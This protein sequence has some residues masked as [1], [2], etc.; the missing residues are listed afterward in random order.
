MSAS[1]ANGTSSVFRRFARNRA[2]NVGMIFGLAAIPIIGAMAVAV[3]YS[4]GTAVKGRLQAAADAA[5]LAAA[6]DQFATTPADRQ[7]IAN[8]VFRANLD[9]TLRI[10]NASITVVET[11]NGLRGNVSAN[12]PTEF[13]RILGSHSMPIAATAEVA[14]QA[15]LTEIALVLDNTGSMRNDMQVLR[16]AARDFVNLV[17]VGTGDQVKVAVV[18][19]VGAVNPGRAALGMSYMDTGAESRFHA[20]FF[21]AK[22]LGRLDNNC[23]FPWENNN[24]GGNNG[25][26]GPNPDPDN[27]PRGND[28]HLRDPLGA[29]D[30]MKSFAGVVRELFG[31]KAAA[32]QQQVTPSTSTPL[33]GTRVGAN[34]ALLP[35]GFNFW[36]N[37][38][39]YNPQRI[40][41]FDLFNRI[42]GAQWK[43]CVEA[44]PYPFDVRDEPPN[45]AN[46]DTLF[47]PYFWPDQANPGNHG[48]GNGNG[49]FNNNYMTDGELPEGW[50]WA[51]GW[52]REWSI[53]KY[54]GVNTA[55]IDETP[56]ST[57]GPNA[58]CPDEIL[59]LTSDRQRVLTKIAGLSHWNS[60]G[61]ITS[62]GLAWG[63][64][65]LSPGAP[66]T[67]GRPYSDDVRKIIVL[68]TDGQN[69]L[70][71]DDNPGSAHKSDY[72]A[73]GYLRDGHWGSDRFDRATEFMN[74]RM[75]EVC[76]NIEATNIEV[77]TM[78]FR[79]GDPAARQLVRGCATTSTHY[80]VAD[81]GAALRNAFRHIAGQI[82]KLR[83]TK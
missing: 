81:T 4:R 58:G 35:T 27:G 61:T 39:L 36:N 83:L 13:M 55:R 79:E 77:Y 20:N 43:G 10:N 40:S 62:E 48:V 25:G 33:S 63:W 29:F 46:P 31:I 7:R 59:P 49:P 70:I 2:G 76:D 60:G 23:R 57:L 65:V 54:N 19:Y 82:S 51:G 75:R 50:R 12:I 56:P 72:T 16:D 64:R 67:E 41:H 30:P 32:A 17:M 38:G 47:V 52:E 74:N 21:E 66:F 34:N 69:A 71:A 80:F 42:P 45:R 15:R 1:S 28:T 8:E 18:P 37:C 5:V 11:G 6:R 24:G 26:G 14:L 3:D 73:Y 22:P 78:I 53:L 9:T 44:R 68:M